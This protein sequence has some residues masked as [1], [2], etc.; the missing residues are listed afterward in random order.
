[1]EI[2]EE[3]HD[4]LEESFAELD[5]IAKVFE[6]NVE[7]EEVP[8]LLEVDRLLKETT[9]HLP[10]LFDR[11]EK[12]LLPDVRRYKE[13]IKRVGK[14][15]G[16]NGSAYELKIAGGNKGVKP[17]QV[18][19]K[20]LILESELNTTKFFLKRDIRPKE[21]KNAESISCKSDFPSSLNEIFGEFDPI[22]DSSD[23]D[24]LSLGEVEVLSDDDQEKDFEG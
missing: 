4:I 14:F 13:I 8:S 2:L 6:K 21:N 12:G 1:M 20:V 19:L 7:D 9:E 23:D 5:R 16:D 10:D 3:K 24:R 17:D 11:D 18:A 15:Y 22:S